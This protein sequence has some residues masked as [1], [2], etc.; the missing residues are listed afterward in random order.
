MDQHPLSTAL[1]PLLPISP[2][3]IYLHHPYHS[4]GYALPAETT[5]FESAGEESQ[6][7]RGAQPGQMN[8]LTVKVDVSALDAAETTSQPST[9][10]AEPVLSQKLFYNSVIRTTCTAIQRKIAVLKSRRNNDHEGDQNTPHKT[11]HPKRKTKGI[12]DPFDAA[13]SAFGETYTPL[14]EKDV[15][16]WDVFVTRLRGMVDGFAAIIA[17]APT[18]DERKEDSGITFTLVVLESQLL[19]KC[20]GATWHALLR[21]NE[22]VRRPAKV[23]S[24]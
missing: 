13:V 8:R 10:L 16:R 5:I 20:L 7:Q 11:K 1:S 9:I 15:Y 21:L 23:R 12:V 2:S 24:R 6:A 17:A 22:M 3:F 4:S 19:Q 14:A 18:V